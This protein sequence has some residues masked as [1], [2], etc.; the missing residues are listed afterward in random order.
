MTMHCE[1][2]DDV[3]VRCHG[4]LEKGFV[5]CGHRHWI[6]HDSFVHEG[7]VLVVRYR[8]QKGGPVV[9]ERTYVGPCRFK[10]AAGIFHEIEVV[11]DE[12]RWDC[13]FVKPD[14]GSVVASVFHH[15]LLE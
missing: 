13:E 5:H 11:S 12:A 8:M 7:S 1:D 10:V 15:E 2:R 3:F 4:P 6:D 9:D 14:A